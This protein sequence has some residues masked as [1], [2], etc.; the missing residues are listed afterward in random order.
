M[1]VV[2]PV[3]SCEAERSFSG[4]K[5]LKTRLR[6][7]MIEEHLNGLALMMIHRD[8]EVDK[9]QVIRTFAAAHPRRMR[10]ESILDDPS[11]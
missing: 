4:V 1:L 11:E 10:L 7:T 8:I 9:K 3:T 2:F 5:R 6:S